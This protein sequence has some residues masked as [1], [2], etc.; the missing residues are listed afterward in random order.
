MLHVVYFGRRS[1]SLKEHP[2]ELACR[3]MLHR[4]IRQSSPYRLSLISED[5]DSR[6]WL[7]D[8]AASEGA[9]WSV[10]TECDPLKAVLAVLGQSGDDH[11]CLL[12]A[13]AAIGP[14]NLVH[15]LRERYLAGG[16][17]VAVLAGLPTGLSPVCF[18]REVLEVAL[19][20]QTV[21]RPT[22]LQDLFVAVE[23]ACQLLGETAPLKV[24]K[25][26]VDATDLGNYAARAEHLD[27][28]SLTAS[29]RFDRYAKR[30]NPTE[31]TGFA[32]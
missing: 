7:S 9:N 14:E 3:W 10:A 23:E 12:T 22:S 21:S 6:P 29:R 16:Y 19:C 13:T 11:C 31:A 17:N 1:L 4:V 24:S 20:L 25:L 18:S 30:V 32:C 26:T 2:S 5:V 27:T 15:L 8:F 28:I